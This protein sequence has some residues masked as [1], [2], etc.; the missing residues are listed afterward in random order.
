MV[1]RFDE[2]RDPIAAA[3]WI[4]RSFGRR[5]GEP[6][7]QHLADQVRLKHPRQL[8]EALVLGEKAWVALSEVLHLRDPVRV[9]RVD[10]PSRRLAEIEHDS[11]RTPGKPAAACVLEFLDRPRQGAGRRSSKPRAKYAHVNLVVAWDLLCHDSLDVETE[12][13]LCV[14]IVPPGRQLHPVRPKH[15]GDVPDH[16]VAAAARRPATSPGLERKTRICI[17]T[18]LARFGGSRSLWP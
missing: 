13:W 5:L 7:R 15:P 4:E 2:R 17:V 1:D 12:S 10:G 18:S 11:R 9:C 3:S 14:A 8:A 16:V 6:Q